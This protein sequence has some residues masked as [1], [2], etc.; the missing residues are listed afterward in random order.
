[1]PLNCKTCGAPLKGDEE[2]C[3][4]CGSFIEYEDRPK[5]KKEK[6]HKN[7]PQIKYA[8][9]IFIITV[10]IFTLGIYGLYW[11]ISR[12]KSFNA[13]SEGVKFPDIGLVIYVIGW[14]MF[15]AFSSS[16][17]QD[18]DPDNAESLAGYGYLVIWIGALWLSFGIKKILK[19]YLTKTC[20][21]E[22]ILKVIAFS[23][24]MIFCFGYIYLQM[25]INKMIKA[26]LLSPDL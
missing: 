18:V 17:A 21:D 4:Y 22:A 20:K 11:Y 25:Q 24:L 12:R 26:E 15:L 13:L 3:P 14:M 10:S 16:D 23:D 7:L 6:E 1:M 2:H 19:D 5:T 8:S 9:E